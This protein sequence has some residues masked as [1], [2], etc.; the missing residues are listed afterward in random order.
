MG[1]S[2]LSARHE[3]EVRGLS[4]CGHASSRESNST[5]PFHRG[6]DLT[7]WAKK[8]MFFGQKA[9]KNMV[10]LVKKVKSAPLWK[11]QVFFHTRF[12]I[13]SYVTPQSAQKIV[14][15]RELSLFRSS[16]ESRRCAIA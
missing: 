9:H 7:F 16:E 3:S 11:G 4:G 15:L 8:T 6:A 5:W 12:K 2:T 1:T 14:T 13:F 10:F